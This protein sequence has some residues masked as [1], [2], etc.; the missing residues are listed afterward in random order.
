[1]AGT[2]TWYQ[3]GSTE[4]GIP[5]DGRLDLQW[6]K[7][8]GARNLTLPRVIIYSDA[9]GTV[10]VWDSDWMAPGEPGWADGRLTIDAARI[11]PT[12]GGQRWAKVAVKDDVPSTS[13]YS[14]LSTFTHAT[15]KLTGAG[16]VA[17]QP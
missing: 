10:E 1:M 9:G 7:Y 6:S 4:P 17:G 5:L 3:P 2:P 15:A 8:S 12:S 11:G 14:T 13:S 16:W